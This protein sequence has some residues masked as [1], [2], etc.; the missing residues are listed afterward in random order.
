MVELGGNISLEGFEDVEHGV[1]IMV[2]K[3]VGSYAKKIADEKGAFDKFTVS[4]NGKEIKVNVSKDGNDFS[5]SASGV[6][7]FFTLGEA[8][9]KAVEEVK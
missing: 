1:L 4:R 2:K 7:L 8:L 5:I 3:M 6:N 9:K